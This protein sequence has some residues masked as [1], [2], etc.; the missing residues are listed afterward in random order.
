MCMK[1]WWNKSVRV[2]LRTGRIKSE[3]IGKDKL[4]NFLGGRGLGGRLLFEEIQPTDDPI[5]KNTLIFA[6][7]PLTGTIVPT[8][9]RFSVSTKSP[10]T[11]TILDSNVGGFLGKEFSSTGFDAL[12]IQGESDVPVIIRIDDEDVSIEETDLWG[13]KVGETLDELDEM[14][15]VIGPAGENLVR[16]ANVVTDDDRV[17]GRGGIGA[18]MGS[19]KLKGIS[20]QGDRRVEIED[21]ERLKD[22]VKK[23]VSKISSSPI[24]S[25]GLKKFGTPILVNL[26]DWL[27]MFPIENF[28]R[29]KDERVDNLS[30]ETMREEIVNEHYGCHACPIRCG[31]KTQT[32][33]EEGKG[34]EYESVWALGANLGNFDLKKTT[35]ANYLCNEL[36]L[37][38]IST[39][40]T[41]AC[42]ME[43]AERE[44]WD[45]TRGFN[46]D[47]NELI[48]M[49]AY[50]K[51]VGDELAGGSKELCNRYGC[52]LSM[53]VKGME[54]PAYDPRGAAGQ[55]LSFATS[56]RGGCHLRGY[57]I[58]EEIFGV[59]KLFD[60]FN[61]SGKAEVVKRSQERNAYLDSLTVCKF[62]SF[63]LDEEYYSRFLEA[64]T[65]I[66]YTVSE[67]HT[68]GERI[69]NMERA[70]NTLNGF[71]K[72]DDQLPDRFSE[73]LSEGASS[74]NVFDM[75][76]MLEDYYKIMGWNEDG[77]PTQKKLDELSLGW[78]TGFDTF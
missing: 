46:N 14:S 27:G 11:G 61:T 33:Q 20:V 22:Y 60:R 5:D 48:K 38:T 52:N 56:N 41:I 7:G 68:I 9:G 49:I 34:P 70:F 64:V 16:F 69:Y 12:I 73:P 66:K 13:K 53:S 63:A 31:L 3:D 50:R 18:V 43:M 17:F 62:S 4:K 55:A 72:M 26:L 35:K 78:L 21:E 45:K 44:I 67:L 15:A 30:G 77:N 2:D 76:I 8:S 36:G 25:R 65:G 1:G 39:G 57:M 29:V 19:K 28:Q 32:D 40:G 58:G 74:G 24:T 42:A 6:R 10:L 75:N 37:D 54:L 47:I 59:P 71:S 23:A 51:G